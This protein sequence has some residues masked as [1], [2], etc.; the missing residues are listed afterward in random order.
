MTNINDVLSWAEEEGVQLHGVKPVR[1]PGRGIGIVAT[2]D[3]EVIAPPRNEIRADSLQAGITIVT[4]PVRAI[5]SLVTVPR[6]ISQRLP[7]DTSIHGLLAAELVRERTGVPTWDSLLPSRADLEA[8]IPLMW[9]EKLRSLLPSRA[10]E[11]VDKQHAKI[12][13]EWDILTKA[14]PETDWD[15]YVY[16]WFLVS[17]RTFYYETPETKLFPWD[18]RLA[19]LP[20]ADL[21]NH[22]DGGCGVLYSPEGYVVTTDRKYRAGEE[23]CTSYGDHSND[24]LLAEYGFVLEQNRW[25]EVCLDDAILPSLS[26]G[27]TAVL[28]TG[29]YLGGY[30]LN[31]AA[32]CERTQAVL[33]VLCDTPG[34]LEAFTDGADV[35]DAVLQ[36]HDDMLVEFLV[37]FI[38]RVKQILK[39]ISELKDGLDSQRSL[40]RR[41]WEQIER[42]AT[43]AV[44]SRRPT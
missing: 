1:T 20:V 38:D 37:R 10:K 9:S 33:S 31:G 16:S 41:R 39:E 35:G 40:L 11:L 30:M 12:R 34:G 21:F 6:R 4:V 27:Q 18:D 3:L 8:S 36:T 17:T 24:F 13:E 19:Q 25:D 26:P 2:K 23:V 14:F 5:R 15:E 44:R 42:L 7:P 29:G 43:Q 22:S 32:L 28:E